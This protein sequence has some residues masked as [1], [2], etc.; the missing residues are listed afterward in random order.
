MAVKIVTIKKAGMISDTTNKAKLKP[1]L[2]SWAPVRM[3]MK[4]QCRRKAKDP[5]NVRLKICFVSK[6][7]VSNQNN[8]Q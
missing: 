2:E 3:R 4:T 1:P 8:F 6:R 7:K 5:S